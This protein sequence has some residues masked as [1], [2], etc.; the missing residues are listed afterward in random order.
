ML[1]VCTWNKGYHH[2][3]LWCNHYDQRIPQNTCKS[4]NELRN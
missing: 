3:I 1:S 4:D 2:Q